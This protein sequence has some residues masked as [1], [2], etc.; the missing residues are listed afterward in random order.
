MTYF[1]LKILNLSYEILTQ[2]FFLRMDCGRTV[3]D[4]GAV[5]TGMNG[6]AGTEWSGGEGRMAHVMVW[7]SAIFGFY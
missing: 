5:N 6:S 7:V 4:G 1:I 3:S 2:I